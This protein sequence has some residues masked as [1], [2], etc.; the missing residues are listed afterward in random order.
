[1]LNLTFRTM[2]R[3]TRAR[4]YRKLKT[5]RIKIFK[6]I[7]HHLRN[8]NWN[9]GK[10]RKLARELCKNIRQSER[11]SRLYYGSLDMAH[12]MNLERMKRGA[13]EL[14]VGQPQN[15]IFSIIN[16]PSTF[17][18][19]PP[20]KKRSRRNTPRNTSPKKVLSIIEDPSVKK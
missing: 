7:R 2:T 18:L 5:N 16:D 19:D 9:K 14:A 17:H 15:M 1:M 8:Q 13:W 12:E 3:S 11:F 10:Q 20:N 6:D 4:T